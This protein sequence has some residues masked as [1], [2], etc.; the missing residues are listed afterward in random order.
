MK[1][2]VKVGREA[3][4]FKSAVAFLDLHDP[5][6]NCLVQFALPCTMQWSEAFFLRLWTNFKIIILKYS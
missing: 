5:N 2:V 4:K 1:S 3:R 6:I